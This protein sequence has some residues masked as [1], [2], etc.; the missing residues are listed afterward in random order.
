MT[1]PEYQGEEPERGT[2]TYTSTAYSNNIFCGIC[3]APVKNVPV[4]Y[5]CMNIDWRCAKCLRR[6]KPV[7]EDR[8]T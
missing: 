1:E 8:G 7:L 2:D 5:E 4:M 3:G 6:D